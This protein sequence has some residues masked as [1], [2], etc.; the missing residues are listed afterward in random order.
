MLM[1]T[2]NKLCKKYQNDKNIL[3]INVEVSNLPLLKTKYKKHIR[4]FPTIIKYDGGLA[5]EEFMN[6]RTFAKLDNFI[7]K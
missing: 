3:I 7:Q 5:S 2:W 4:G 6:E 1:P